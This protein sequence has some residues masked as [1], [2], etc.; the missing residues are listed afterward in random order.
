MHRHTEIRWVAYA[1]RNWAECIASSAEDQ[2]K[3]RR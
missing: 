3:G 2:K 1:R